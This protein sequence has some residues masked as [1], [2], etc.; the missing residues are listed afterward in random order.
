MKL[1]D[2]KTDL[3]GRIVTVLIEFD[4]QR[5]QTINVY[6]PNNHNEREIFFDNRVLNTQT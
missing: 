5:F 6:G 4:G 3:A 2:Y 1:V